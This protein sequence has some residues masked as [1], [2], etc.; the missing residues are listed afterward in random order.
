MTDVRIVS[1]ATLRETVADWLL[2]KNGLLDEREELANYVKV[3]LMTDRLSDPI[4]IRPDPDSDDCRGWWGDMEAQQIWRGWP[5][6]TKNW[7]LTRAKISDP[8]SFEGDTVFRA[9]NY[10]REAIQPLVEMRMAT[11]IDVKAVRV[12]IERIDVSVIIYRG[13]E[14]E[15]ELTFQ[16]LWNTL[17]DIE[18]KS[19]YGVKL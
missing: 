1:H 3:A 9:E 8:F 19:P 12:G 7:L 10:T 15:I 18:I 4:E 5:I 2:R 13:P 16:D 6:G 17:R 11:A 14:G